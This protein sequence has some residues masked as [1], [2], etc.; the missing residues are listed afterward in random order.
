MFIQEIGK[1]S[2]N[3]KSQPRSIKN[4]VSPLLVP[5][6]VQRKISPFH[7]KLYRMD[8]SKRLSVFAS[9]RFAFFNNRIAPNS[10]FFR[11]DDAIQKRRRVF[12]LRLRGYR[13]LH[14]KSC[15]WPD[16]SLAAKIC[17]GGRRISRRP[18]DSQISEQAPLLGE[19]ER[20]GPPPK[21]HLAVYMDGG[22]R[23]TPE[24]NGNHRR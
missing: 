19:Q 24:I 16:F 9:R 17:G 20:F 14:P 18:N 22:G 10:L 23:T 13:H 3:P 2:I 7:L 11:H 21:G 8:A 12:C 4:C 6:L 15:R 5:Y 1:R